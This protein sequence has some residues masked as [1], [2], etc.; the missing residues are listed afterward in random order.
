MILAFAYETATGAKIPTD[1]VED[2][3]GKYFHLETGE[4]LKQIVAK[5]SKSLK[6]VVNPDDVVKQYGADSLRLYEMFMGP[7][8]VIKPWT[9]TGVKGVFGFLSR[10]TR[11][12]GEAENINAAA[13]DM[14]ILKGLHQTIKKVSQDIEALKFNTAISQMMIFTNLCIKKGKVTK[15]TAEAFTCVLA[16]FA[17]HLAEE[18][19]VLYGNKPSI[20]QQDFPVSNETYL[21]EDTFDYPVSFNGK[22]R[23]RLML[24]LSMQAAEIE[25]IVREERQSAKWIEGKQ[26]NKIIFVHGKIINVVVT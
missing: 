22:L 1:L 24:P 2:R 16:P 15:Q 25:K 23:F 4:E 26:I 21:Q 18:L 13:D 11:F 12:F 14:E 19:W 8:D 10:V 5:M 6:N 17:P 3:E 20:I 9:D 7:L